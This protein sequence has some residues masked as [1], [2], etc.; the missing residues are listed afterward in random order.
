[1]RASSSFV[2]LDDNRTLPH[3][4][5]HVFVG[6]R[7]DYRG[8]GVLAQ[9]SP[10][11]QQLH[12]L[13]SSL[14]RHPSRTLDVDAAAVCVVAAHCPRTAVR[15]IPAGGASLRQQQRSWRRRCGEGRALA[16]IDGAAEHGV[17]NDQRWQHEQ[18]TSTARVSI[19][20]EKMAPERGWSAAPLRPTWSTAAVLSLLPLEGSL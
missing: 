10:Q 12:V 18:P 15:S 20:D 14:A 13:L 3:A 17:A 9:H 8:I 2:L 4:R 5:K 7:G 11:W 6:W 1:M 19:T 16:V